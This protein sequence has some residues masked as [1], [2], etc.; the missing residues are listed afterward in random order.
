V[1]DRTSLRAWLAQMLN[2][3]P[4]R[5]SKKQM[6]GHSFSGKSKYQRSARNV[7]RLTQTKL[8]QLHDDVRRLRTDFLRAWAIDERS[9]RSA[10]N[11]YLSLQ[12]WLDKVQQ[13]VPTPRIAHRPG[14]RGDSKKQCV[15]VL[16]VEKQPVKRRKVT[17]EKL[18]VVAPQQQQEQEPERE[19]S[20]MTEMGGT[21]HVAP[22]EPLPI[23]I[24]ALASAPTPIPALEAP[25]EGD[26]TAASSTLSVPSLDHDPVVE[27][28]SVADCGES[29]CLGDWLTSSIGG[30]VNL[31]D[32]QM[33]SLN[34]VNEAR[35]TICED[36]VQFSLHLGDQE[37]P[38]AGVSMTRK[39]SRLV[40][41]FGAPSGWHAGDEPKRTSLSEWTDTD[42]AEELA[43]LLDPGIFGWEDAAPVSHVT[44]GS[45][46]NLM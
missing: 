29:V 14:L 7:E 9:R 6:H 16:E 3:C 20:Q 15:E 36:Q 1:A 18:K 25:V 40:I 5:I 45:T 38:M 42:L 32:L 41:D 17:A 30:L 44:Y 26:A 31:N 19:T 24:P 12:E 21:D 37:N 11:G 10:G 43:S 27:A 35:Y 13:L 2:C 46:H 23:P 4:M 39:S 22:L 33:Q 28:L 34:H 8:D